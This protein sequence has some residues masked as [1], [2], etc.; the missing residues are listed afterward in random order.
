MLTD[1]LLVRRLSLASHSAVSNPYSESYALTDIAPGKST[2]KCGTPNGMPS[3]VQSTLTIAHSVSK[4]NAPVPTNRL[5][6]RIDYDG[7]QAAP[8]GPSTGKCFA[9]LVIGNLQGAGF[10][11]GGWNPWDTLRS[12]ET[13]LGVT[14]VLPTAATLS[15]ANIVRMIAGEP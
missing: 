7:L 3:S 2:R 8:D 10:D 6:V 1:P 4:E 12:F 5:L 15:E 14:A 13:L 9:Y 11:D